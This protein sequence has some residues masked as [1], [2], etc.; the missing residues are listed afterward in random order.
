M[1]VIKIGI[2]LPR[3]LLE[4]VDAAA[5]RKGQ[6]RSEFVRRSLERALA[7]EVSPRVLAE[8]RALYAAIEEDD[9][10]LAEDFLAVAAETLP[11]YEEAG[12]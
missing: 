7:E 3:P 6:S 4:R 2:S 8:A 12:P 10:A 11:P 1:G 5:R 9:R